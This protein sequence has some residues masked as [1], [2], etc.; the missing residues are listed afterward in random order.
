MSWIICWSATTSARS[1]ATGSPSIPCGPL[2]H[3]DCIP[4]LPV[5]PLTVLLRSWRSMSGRWRKPVTVTFISP[6]P[7]PWVKP[8][9]FCS[10]SYCR[11]CVPMTFVTVTARRSG[12]ILFPSGPGIQ[13]VATS[14]WPTCIAVVDLLYMTSDVPV[15]IEII[16]RSFC[17]SGGVGSFWWL[18]AVSI[19]LFIR[20]MIMP[21]LI[22]Q[23]SGSS[24]YC[25]VAVA[26]SNETRSF[27]LKRLEKRA[28]GAARDVARATTPTRATPSTRTAARPRRCC[29]G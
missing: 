29:C 11:C 14:M 4:T 18:S 3:I 6:P 19:T 16:L 23:P 15:S 2:A 9:K 25:D 5:H 13:Q 24:R 26:S 22:L 10:R 8:K 20:L 1:R 28:C 17:G 21:P 12:R 7:S 27:F